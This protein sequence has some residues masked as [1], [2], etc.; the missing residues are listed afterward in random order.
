MQ[1]EDE[2]EKSKDEDEKKEE[3][4]ITIDSVASTANLVHMITDDGTMFSISTSLF[5]QEIGCPQD[6]NLP[7]TATVVHYEN[8]IISIKDHNSA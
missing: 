7:F 6:I 5:E 1:L 3:K 8:H 4:K 2:S